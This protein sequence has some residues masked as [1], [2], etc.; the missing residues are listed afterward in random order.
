MRYA[1]HAR[2]RAGASAVI[3]EGA[4]SSRLYSRAGPGI[5][6]IS[7]DA[8]NRC[9]L[10]MIRPTG[11]PAMFATISTWSPP[12]YLHVNSLHPGHLLVVPTTRHRAHAWSF[13][14][15]SQSQ[16]SS[17]DRQKQHRAHRHRPM[18]RRPSQHR[19]QAQCTNAHAR[20]TPPYAAWC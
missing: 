14:H 2:S 4:G 9:A 20:R 12:P 5:Y 3:E 6:S 7:H 18:H 8:K 11:R 13:R 1:H 16:A 10:L 15:C 17:V 19:A